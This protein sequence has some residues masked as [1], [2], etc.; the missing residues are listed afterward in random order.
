MAQGLMQCNPVNY[1]F[2]A[3]AATTTSSV[4]NLNNADAYAIVFDASSV[5][6]TS[7]TCDIVMQVSYDKGTTYINAPLRSAQITSAGVHWNVMRRGLG[8][9]EAALTQ[10]GVADTG[11]ALNKNFV[12]DPA[13]VKFKATIGG[14]NPS[15][16][17]KV[18]IFEVPLGTNGAI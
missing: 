7:P 13:Y 2:G 18:H 16:T 5:T 9:G 3:I 17:L 12:F 4:L 15:F 6:G 10:A 11:G 14:T 8:W 1:S